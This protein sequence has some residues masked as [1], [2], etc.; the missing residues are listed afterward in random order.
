MCL[1]ECVCVCV[2]VYIYTYI[3][4]DNTQRTEAATRSH[5][6]G[7]RAH[8]NLRQLSRRKRQV[9]KKNIHISPSK[10]VTL[11]T[12][13]YR[14][15]R[16]QQKSLAHRKSEAHISLVRSGI[17]WRCTGALHATG[18]PSQH[19]SDKFCFRRAAFH[20]GL[21]SKVGHAAAKVG[22]AADKAAALRISLYIDGCGVVAHPVHSPSCAPLLLS[23]LLSHSIPFPRVH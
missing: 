21:K 3:G 9:K 16:T 6:P 17:W 10:A 19:N 23:T 15:S 20:H 18:I 8:D 1:C 14:A 11:D 12:S 2:C 7:D 22:L 4:H 13:P 5:G